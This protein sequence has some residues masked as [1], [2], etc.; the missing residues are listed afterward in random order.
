MDVNEKA[1]APIENKRKPMRL[2]GLNKS[3]TGTASGGRLLNRPTVLVG[4]DDTDNLASPGT[5]W[6]AQS[7]IRQLASEGFGE[8]LGITRHQLLKDPRVPYTSHNSSACLALGTCAGSDV[9]ALERCAAGFLRNH[10]AEG[11]DPGLAITCSDVGQAD[12]QA[13]T[14]FGFTAKRELVDQA[15][16]W[17]C[18]AAHGVRLSGHGGTE[19]GVIGALAAVG[20]H[21]HGSDGFFLW[22]PGVRELPPGWCSYQHLIHTLPIDDARTLT[23]D[24]PT[25]DTTIEIGPWI[26]PLL[27]NGHAVLLLERIDS[28]DAPPRWRTAPR[29]VVKQH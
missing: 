14:E 29:D 24:R 5:G 27:L 25:P 2:N 26:R 19:D 16:A 9:D 20:L 15:S 12:H 18:A 22:M 1:H 11:S 21:L 23:G 8:P 13:L 7:L 4:I 3:Q 17:A 28:A 6:I 10:A